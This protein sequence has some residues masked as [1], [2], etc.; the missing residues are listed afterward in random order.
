MRYTLKRRHT[1]GSVTRKQKGGAPIP[2][3]TINTNLIGDYNLSTLAGTVGS[4]TATNIPAS[5]TL[6]NVVFQN[7][8]GIALDKAGNLYFSAQACIM[9]VTPPQDA[10]YTMQGNVPIPLLPPPHTPASTISVYAGS[11][12]LGSEA[13]TSSGSAIRFYNLSG[14]AY[15]PTLNCLY[16]SDCQMHQVCRVY[17]DSSGTVQC[18]NF[19][20]STP[21]VLNT[22]KGL[23]IGQDGSL[24]I[25]DSL[26]NRVVRYPNGGSLTATGTGVV[27]VGTVSDPNGVAV[28]A[29]GVV[30]VSSGTHCIYAFTP[31]GASAYTRSIYSG[32]L[33]VRGVV[34]GALNVA[35][36]SFP[37]NLY[38][39]SVNNVIYVY[40]GGNRTIRLIN[41]SLGTVSSL[42]GGTAS[43]LDGLASAGAAFLGSSAIGSL[44]N[45]YGQGTYSGIT[46]DPNGYVYIT[47][48]GSSVVKQAIPIPDSGTPTVTKTFYD[49][50]WAG[51]RAS[52]AQASSAVA[53][54]ASSAVAQN[55]S[56][57][58]A[59]SISGAQQSSAVAQNVSS[60]VAQNVSSA[61]AERISGAQ[62]S[63]AVAQQASSAVAQN[64]S[65]ALAQSISGAQES[66]A[67]AQKVSSALAQSIS[68]AEASSAVAQQASSALAQSISGAQQ[69]SAV[70]QEASSAVA[71]QAS[72]ALAQ[73]ISG[74]RE[75][76]AT[77]QDASSALAQ[78]ISGAQASSA[79]AQLASGSL[80]Q[81][82]S[83]AIAQTA[84][85]A[86][87]Q[88]ASSAKQLQALAG[89]VSDKDAIVETI[90]GMQAE[91]QAQIA[92]FYSPSSSDSA[93]ASARQS[94]TT[95]MEDIQTQWQALSETCA[96]IFA[97]A[98]MYQDRALQTVIS[99]PY[100]ESMGLIKLYD[101][102]RKNYVVI[103]SNGYIVPNSDTPAQ[104]TLQGGGGTSSATASGGILSTDV[105]LANDT[106]VS[107]PWA[108]YFD[109]VVRRYFYINTSTS[110]SQYEHPFPPIFSG[111]DKIQQDIT[112]NFLPS[113]WIKLQSASKNLPYYLQVLSNETSWVHPKPPPNSS[114]LTEVVDATLFSTYKKYTDPGTGK[115]FY[116]NSATLEA[117]WNFPDAAFNVGP[118]TAQ[119]ASSALAQ[120][121][122][123]ARDSSAVA[124]VASSALA[125]AISGARESSAVA[126]V[127]SSALAQAIS[128]AE[129]SSALAQAISGARDSSAVA[130]VA[131]SALAQAISGARD[132]SAVAQQA[133]SAL[134]QSISGAQQSSAVAQDASSALAQ[135]ISGA[136]ASS[137][138]AQNVSSALAQS[139]SG[140]QASSAV[141]Q[142]ASSALAQYI[143]GA[144]DAY[145]KGQMASS[146]LMQS[147]S[148]AQQSSAV[149]QQASSALAQSI[150]GA[151]Q[152]SAIAQFASS[153][154][155][156]ADSSAQYQAA[157]SAVTEHALTGFIQDKDSIKE[158]MNPIK[159]DVNNLITSAYAPGGGVT[160]ETITQL[161][162][163]VAQLQSMQNDLR[164]AA[165]GIFSLHDY[166][167][168]PSLQ[169]AAA[170]PKLTTLGLRRVF[171][172]LRN[173]Y[174]V[175]DSKG[176]IVKNPVTPA[177][178]GYTTF[179]LRGGGPRAPKYSR[180][181][182]SGF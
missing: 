29:N 131:S 136:Q 111:T 43:N 86:I 124:Q 145:E 156:Q 55:V 84:S 60:A 93:K 11:P 123:G 28:L 40:D 157:S 50:Y 71:Q 47:D 66:S 106:T 132:S 147:I 125:Q 75:S 88:T 95:F 118:S 23:A 169:T 150:S 26:N 77:A 148:G 69:S 53:Q 42:F 164:T 144:R 8:R 99:D 68:G 97:I 64:V 25:A 127:A 79:E 59:E 120:A 115:P 35:T 134:A 7:L 19:I 108:S 49:T 163:S 67:T 128:G 70:A 30:Y 180:K 130:Q 137:A 27:T 52:S 51:Q 100:V 142:V 105:L 14:M 152:S 80:G 174:V 181:V 41:I 104:R 101:T 54:Q 38:G 161:H 109:T 62:Q 177:T 24:F 135:S 110:R 133:S 114:Q 6:K 168:D 165:N 138:T 102:M 151:Q 153:A 171:D 48:F 20:P 9:K 15:D 129:A 166:Y 56:S 57:A 139:I 178:R 92:I 107:P 173:R 46:V 81:R 89:P 16:V 179:V 85:S 121:I 58:L 154:V 36:F 117:Q 96:A 13:T 122:S 167:Q 44:P 143:S 78:N 32:T 126:Q 87:A 140:A 155:Q 170:D 65:S 34:N 103:D 72:S 119:A 39:D 4:K 162:D 83:S 146:A 172:T 149:A 112:T 116:V 160:M 159:T 45:V 22:P 113:G 94:I 37:Q 31:D 74:A 158:A 82:T 91:I 10:T 1:G 73:S 61:L 17:T 18:V 141:A 21:R 176:A 175:I 2:G 63:S 33:N 3:V 90:R 98:P 5:P 12:T 76:S 182:S